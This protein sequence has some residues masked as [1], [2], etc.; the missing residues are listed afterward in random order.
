MSKPLDE[1]RQHRR[2]PVQFRSSFS[3]VNVVGGEGTLA[4]LS[5][6]GC[7]I[8]CR[9]AVKPGT[10]LQLKIHLPNEQAPLG[11]TVAAVRWTHGETFGVEFMDMHD[12]EWKRL[13]R[14]IASV[15]LPEAEPI[16]QS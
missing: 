15:G 1:K 10:E 9:I 7:R 11:I 12:E 5:V 2:F 14:F 6:R 8:E 3:S 13:G 4:D 16:D